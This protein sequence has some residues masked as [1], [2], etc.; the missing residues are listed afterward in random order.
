MPQTVSRLALHVVSA[1]AHVTVAVGGLAILEVDGVQ[2]AVA[3]EPV[4]A[5]FGREPRV[6]SIAHVDAMQIF[7]QLAD[8]LEIFDDDLI[9]NRSIRSCNIRI[10]F[11]FELN[12]DAHDE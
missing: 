4:V 12:F 11:V 1:R 7:W 8:D 9:V 10:L 3:I 2:H 5:P 6:G